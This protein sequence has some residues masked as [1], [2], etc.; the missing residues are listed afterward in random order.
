[1]LKTSDISVEAA[2]DFVILISV[3][4]IMMSNAD[5]G[6][7][8]AESGSHS[9]SVLDLGLPEIELFMRDCNSELS[10]VSESLS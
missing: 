9:S 7:M 8:D 1:M 10:E 3:L 5:V 2:L 6:V 4:S